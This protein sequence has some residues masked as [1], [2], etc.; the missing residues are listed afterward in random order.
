MGQ[1]VYA[2]VWLITSHHSEW[3]QSRAR[4]AERGTCKGALVAFPK[5][6]TEN[7]GDDEDNPGRIL[8]MSNNAARRHILFQA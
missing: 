2:V 3:P 4:D 7:V 6:R 5:K 1:H 8:T